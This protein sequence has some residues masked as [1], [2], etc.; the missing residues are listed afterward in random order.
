MV[1]SYYSSSTLQG[2]R[3]RLRGRSARVAIPASAILGEAR[4]AGLGPFR[5]ASLLPLVREQT[6]VRASVRS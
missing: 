2:L 5:T 4:E 6:F 3:R 1:F